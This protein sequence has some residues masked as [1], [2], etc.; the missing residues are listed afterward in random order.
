MRSPQTSYRNFDMIKAVTKRITIV[1]D[2][3]T[4]NLDKEAYEFL[5]LRANDNRSAYISNI[6]KADKQRLIADQLFRANQ[7]E[8][9]ESYQVGLG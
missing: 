2:R 7:E 6:L 1:S 8:A 4:I 9:D 3:I 5:E